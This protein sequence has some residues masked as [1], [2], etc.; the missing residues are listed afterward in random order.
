[1][2]VTVYGSYCD[3][4]QNHTVDDVDVVFGCPVPPPL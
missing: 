2:K 1:M 4:L 3:R